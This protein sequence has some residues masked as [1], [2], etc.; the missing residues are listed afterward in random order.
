MSRR[1]EVIVAIFATS[2]EPG[3]SWAAL[4][5]SRA[6]S[7]KRPPIHS[8][9]AD[10][11]R[12]SGLLGSLRKALFEVIFRLTDRGRAVIPP[13]EAG[14]QAMNPTEHPGERR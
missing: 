4:R 9:P 8:K 12:T 10:A 3:A 1:G 13:A 11:I 2:A 7:S 6:A 5:A 14:V